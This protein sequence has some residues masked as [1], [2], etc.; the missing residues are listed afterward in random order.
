MADARLNRP[1]I[2]LARQSDLDIISCIEDDSFSEPYPTSLLARLL[3]DHP[4]SFLVAEVQPGTVVGYSVASEESDI[5]HLISIGVLREYRRRGVGTA[6]ILALISN[7][8]SDVRGVRLEVKQGN[9]DAIRLYEDLGFRKVD[10]I[11]NYYEDG[12]PAVKM[13]FDVKH[14]QHLE[15]S[16]K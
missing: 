4:L 10:L 13:Q 16:G 6:L 15:S 11:Q 5:L 3:H 14:K 2:R 7:A 9:T 8:R 12:S 1:H